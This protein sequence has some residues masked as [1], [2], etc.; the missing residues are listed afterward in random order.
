MVEGSF[1]ERFLGS[2]T[3]I[4][5]DGQGDEESEGSVVEDEESSRGPATHDVFLGHDS[6]LDDSPGDI[7]QLKS[8]EAEDNRQVAEGINA[9]GYSEEVDDIAGQV[10]S[11]R[12]KVS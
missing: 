2:E 7:R 1:L 4:G 6:F 3:S 10:S 11:H 5:H 12:D 8:N 9:N